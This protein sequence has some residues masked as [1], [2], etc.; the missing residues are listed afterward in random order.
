MCLLSHLRYF[1]TATMSHGLS[2]LTV[3]FVVTLMGAMLFGINALQPS[4]QEFV[5]TTQKLSFKSARKL[6][7]LA[8]LRV[9]VAPANV[10]FL[11]RDFQ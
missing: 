11:F 4:C 5:R 7:D 10:C 9:I 1:Q 6:R 8:S 2:V 3:S